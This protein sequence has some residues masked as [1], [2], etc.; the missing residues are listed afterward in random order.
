MKE[1]K[2]ICAECKQV[3]TQKAYALWH[4]KPCHFDFDQCFRALNK[5]IKELEKALAK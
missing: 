5:R 4:G 3:I 1:G 2:P